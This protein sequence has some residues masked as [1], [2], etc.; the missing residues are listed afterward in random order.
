ML[1]I[2]VSEI[3]G[4]LIALSVPGFKPLFDKFILQRDITNGE[5]T[6]K[7]SKLQQSSKGGTALR[8]LN[9]R[10]GHDVLNSRDTSA[11]GATVYRMNNVTADNRSEN[12]ADGILV[13]MDFR[14][15]EDMQHVQS[16]SDAGRSWK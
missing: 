7:A 11:E 15:K 9:L 13:Q 12:S 10:P 1:V 4:T 16:G 2:E 14:L 8:S 3:G 5:N 6:G